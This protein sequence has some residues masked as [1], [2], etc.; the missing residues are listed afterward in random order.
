MLDVDLGAIQEKE[1]LAVG[2]PYTLG[3]RKLEVRRNKANDGDVIYAEV[4]VDGHP[5]DSFIHYWS[6]K[7]GGLQARTAT[8][9]VKKFFETID[10]PDLASG[11]LTDATIE[12]LSKMNF[13]GTVK[14]ETWNEEIRVKLDTVLGS[15]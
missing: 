9:S 1:P 11:H 4:T 3:F 10:R 14:H 13:V 6:L 7:S 15:A 12:E 8:I 2:G 5:T